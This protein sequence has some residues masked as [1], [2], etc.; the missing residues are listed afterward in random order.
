MNLRI[1]F[2]AQP[3]D[4]VQRATLRALWWMALAFTILD[5]PV[6][7]AIDRVSGVPNIARWL[8]NSTGVV[9]AWAFQP[10]ASLVSRVAGRP[11]RIHGGA[12]LMF[13]T[14]VAMAACF[15]A[16]PVALSAPTELVARYGAV[17]TV[18]IYRLVFLDYIGYTLVRLFVIWRRRLAP[19]SGTVTDAALRSQIRLQ[20]LGWCLGTLYCA[21]ECGSIALRLLGVLPAD[22]YSLGVA[23]FLL[24]GCFAAILSGGFLAAWGWIDR[25]RT[26]HTLSRFWHDL[27]VATPGIALDPPRPRRLDL[28]TLTDLDFRLYRRVTEIR[29]G[30]AALLPYLDATVV[31]EARADEEATSPG[32][33]AAHAALVRVL[34]AGLRAK[35]AG[36]RAADPAHRSPLREHANARADARYLRSVAA[37]Y[38]RATASI[39]ANKQ[40]GEHG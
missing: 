35:R 38:A 29:D 37:A 13:A 18:A 4:V 22:A 15:F 36:E 10:V 30:V 7:D 26:Y 40:G 23:Y 21:Y 20:T 6:Y 16:S 19:V 39:D 27:F 14:L 1:S 3:Q 2:R 25:F 34:L 17:P 24:G 32:G 11:T 9:G 8:G 5:P 12:G 28:G 31:A 33:T